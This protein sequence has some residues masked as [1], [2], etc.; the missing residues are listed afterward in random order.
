MQA[1]TFPLSPQ[2]GGS[3]EVLTLGSLP[4]VEFSVNV[5]QSLELGTITISESPQRGAYTRALKSEKSLVLL[6]Q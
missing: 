5:G 4:S 6:C 2:C 3:A 1:I